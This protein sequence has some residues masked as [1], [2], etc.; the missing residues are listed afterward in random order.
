MKLLVQEFLETHSA[1]ELREQHGVKLRWSDKRLG[2]FTLNYDQIEVRDSDPLS[3]QCR[4]LILRAS[5]VAVHGRSDKPIGPT[6]IVARP[7]DRFFNHG[8][9]ACAP[10]DFDRARFYEKI[11]GTLCIV[12]Y[13]EGAWH[14][15]TRSV[16]DADVVIAGVTGLTFR[17]LFE[18]VVGGQLGLGL[19]QGC[20]YM[21]E[22]TAAENQVVC[23]Y[24]KEQVWLLGIRETQS[25][26]EIMPDW[27]VDIY[28]VCP[29]HELTIGEMMDW[30]TARDPSQYEGLVVC[31]YAFRR[32]KVK[33]AA[34]MALAH[35][36]DS[37]GK[38]ARSMLELILLGKDDDARPMLPAYLLERMDTMKA[39]L[40]KE[41][42]R[43]DAAWSALH[44]PDRKAFA[45]AIQASA[46]P[47]DMGA[48][49]ARFTGKCADAQSWIAGQKRDGSWS[50]STLDGLL[51]RIGMVDAA[52]SDET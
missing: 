3:Q 44:V 9:E 40:A 48:L 5:G 30:V 36:R 26:K 34:Y 49:M 52:A 20:T 39:G 24:P 8:A 31:D 37:V 43:I 14:V 18:R 15:A 45:L 13:D 41:L 2:V 4:G 11:D 33:S 46:Y 6:T 47:N 19:A 21:F 16:P 25:G 10:V 51:E 17:A 29:H 7:F 22:L 27:L 28:P 23:T 32:C 38:S 12:H 50:A 1:L 42:Q 35:V